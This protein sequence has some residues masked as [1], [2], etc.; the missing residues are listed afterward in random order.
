MNKVKSH[1]LRINFNPKTYL[2][3]CIGTSPEDSNKIN[4][5]QVNLH[6]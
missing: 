4:R 3:I 2:Q 1:R 6:C 5:A